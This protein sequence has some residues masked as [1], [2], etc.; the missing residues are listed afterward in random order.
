MKHYILKPFPFFFLTALIIFWP[1]T[2]AFFTF[3][4]DALTYYYP[5]RTLISDAL[6]NGELPLWTPFINMGYPIHADMQSGAWNPVIWIF[7]F[8]TH[9]NLYG[10]HAEFLFYIC[11]A[12]I[13]FYHLSLSFGNSRYASLVVALV[14]Q[15]SGF[16][17]DSVQ[18][19]NCISAACYLPFA[20][21]FF[22]KVLEEKK[23]KD[24]ILLSI[25][26]WLFFTG[27]YPSLFIITIYF[28]LAYF[29]YCFITHKEKKILLKKLSIPI[30]FS[31]ISFL[32]LS[33][34][35][36]ISFVNHLSE[37]SRG[38]NQSLSFVLEN[39]MNPSTSFSLLSPFSTT[40]SNDWLRSEIL[41]RNIYLSIPVLFFLI[42]GCSI[43]KIRKDKA[44][45]FFIS[46]ALIM[47]GLAWGG[48]F[49]FRQIA[50]YI[51]PLMKSFRHAG[52]FRLFT[53]LGLLLVA[54]KSITAWQESNIFKI[55][56]IRP[57]FTFALATL[58]LIA[59]GC[60]FFMNYEIFNNNSLLSIAKS[61]Y[62]TP[63]FENRFILQFPCL[64]ITIVATYFTI[65]RKKP[66]LLLVIVF[67]D[68]FLATM[69]NI[70]ITVIG[71]K[72]FS[73]VEKMINRN[74]VAFPLPNNEKIKSEN[75]LINN[76]NNL[77][78]SVIPFIKVISRNDYYIT[79][80]N[81]KNQDF[82]YASSIKDSVFNNP[83]LYFADTLVLDD[84]VARLINSK[85]ALLKN[86]EDLSILSDKTISTEI[87]I[88]SISA[89]KM[90]ADM[91][92]VSDG[93]LIYLQNN[94][95]G[96]NVFIDDI[97][98]KI[99]P[100]NYTYMGVF[101]SKGKHHIKFEYKPNYI[102]RS[103]YVSIVFLSAL[104]LFYLFLI[105]SNKRQI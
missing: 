100:V 9:Y 36:I 64:L 70:P 76:E 54:S 34:P 71:A 22:K 83:V 24:A 14:Y 59:L 60:I 46:M 93:F 50:Y 4:N 31:A 72:S 19:F 66:N 1:I 16:M 80:G 23:I 44:N 61:F 52:L 97:P 49:F 32:I 98:Q 81:L 51:L 57:F 29:I 33:L 77:T 41:M 25:T 94:Y 6:N 27:G 26:L 90:E 11:L 17:V 88:T 42:L 105:F 82:F 73:T 86:K 18:F 95:N 67:I 3:K 58:T 8:L 74:K 56:K 15:C 101:T 45:I 89:N 39:S 69:Y 62:S 65:I 20:L 91:H 10:F 75:P 78:G 30:L 47:L 96:W 102:I 48:F 40:A 103:W 99:V 2:F 104:I 92:N 87:K 13:G 35:A 43:P 38:K 53:I 85:I 37:I 5:I 21:L 68:L 84:G 63:N 55:K 79:P 7:S 12:G 28:L